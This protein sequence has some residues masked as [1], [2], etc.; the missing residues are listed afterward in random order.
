MKTIIQRVPAVEHDQRSA[1]VDVVSCV[2]H[3]SG[4]LAVKGLS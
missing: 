2:V 4:V 3:G 1:P